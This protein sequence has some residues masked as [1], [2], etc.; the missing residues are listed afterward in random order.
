MIIANSQGK[1]SLHAACVVI[2]NKAVLFCGDSGSGKSSLALH[3]SRKGHPILSDDM[4]NLE[5][6]DNTNIF[7]CPSVP[8]IK[9]SES[10]LIEIGASKN[11]FLSIPAY[12]T[13]YSYPL[14]PVD[15]IEKIPIGLI[16]FPAFTETVDTI[17][18]I[19]GS[20]KINLISKHIYRKK[21][22]Q[23]LP[24]FSHRNKALFTIAS[25]IQM[26]EYSRSALEKE[27]LKSMEFIE[28]QLSLLTQ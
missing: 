28:Q 13:K 4:I 7:A 19:N 8:R 27:K 16:I 17:K 11:D 6:D 9:L 25:K 15:Q 2:N 24:I 14:E 12:K 3:F 23:T 1:I 10:D 20:K 21:L 18:T 5:I 26:Y 22:G